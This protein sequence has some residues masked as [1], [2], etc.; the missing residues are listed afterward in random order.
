V[1]PPVPAEELRWRCPG[2]SLSYHTTNDVPPAE[3]VVGQEA[4]VEALLFGLAIDARGQHVFV[5]GVQ[6]TGRLTLV[7]S[8]LGDLEP[9]TPEAADRCYVYAFDHPDQ[10]RLVSLPPGDGPAF[11][12]RLDELARFVV[13]DLRDLVNTD[14]LRHRTHAI[15]TEADREISALSDPFDNALTDA[16]L[17]LVGI[18]EGD[19]GPEPAIVPVIEGEPH[20]FDQVEDRV[21]AG[22]MDAQTLARMRTDADRLDVE[23][24]KVTAAV[25]RVRKRARRATRQL[26]QQ[27]ARR[28][29]Q[30]VVADIRRAYPQVGAWLDDVVEDASRRIDDV[31]T[32]PEV[33]DR[34][35]ANVLVSRA[36]GAPRPVVIEN[37]PTVQNLLGS[38]DPG[39]HERNPS[40]RHLGVHAGS[41]L[42]ADGGTL[43]L[44]AKDVL[45]EPGAWP[46]LT[47]TLRTGQIEWWSSEASQTT[48]RAPGV[49]P[50]P[51]P[52]HL[53]VVLIGE[54]ALYF[55][56]D[57]DP[58]FAQLFKVL[59]DLDGVL[60][61]DADGIA[62][63]GRVIARIA[64]DEGLLPFTS[65]AVGA[66]VEQGARWAEE[67]GKLTA[68]LARVADL[69]REASFH[70]KARGLK[71]VDASEIA[72]ALVAA[73]RRNDLPGRR[74]RERLAKGIVQ[75]R[76]SGVEVG[77]VNG[78]AV[79]QAGSLVYSFPTR[80][81]ATV[82]PGTAGTVHVEREAE[83]S[84]Q[85]HTKGFFIVRGLLRHLLHPS[86]PVVFDGSVAHEQS[87]GGIDGDSASGAEF[88]C[89]VSAL[90]R[91]PVR[92]GVAMTGAVD[93]HGNV[94]AIG[95][96]NEK[97]EG[98][99]DACNE[100]AA[101]RGGPAADADGTVQGVVIPRANV[102][103]LQ[104]RRDVV[105]ACRAGRFAV[106]A[107]DRIEQALELLLDHPGGGPAIVERAVE[108][109]RELWTIVEG[110]GSTPRAAP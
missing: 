17:A 44:L 104:L 19:E 20:T 99:F 39:A 89:L 62:L 68:R 38:I 88:C 32:H 12:A 31:D 10:P 43:I 36:R 54:P 97:I 16:G 9:A 57:D 106:W 52:V 60:P 105:A 21:R 72:R 14:S 51:I 56:L 34:Y 74:Y 108:R 47:R 70:A 23:R 83:L 109:A 58:D 26:V 28:V 103:E 110:V 69:A 102:G 90:T 63:Y 41:I 18:V 25:V 49:K 22:A 11:A 30:D 42:R 13:E 96:V 67:A 45:S 91:I 3:G 107:V 61:R 86:H 95:G 71:V 59:V 37:V 24:E 77:Q 101:A 98:F 87:Y 48:M 1:L 80:I 64:R 15:E 65:A 40:G 85:I 92:Q 66:L 29:L 2:T 7:R 93:Q 75:V 82:A 35:R 5:R 76:T 33:V 8:L 79:V 81:T 4:A 50:E 73:R 46:A 94:L 6:G 55:A 84:G 100:A 27:E 78:L 53:K